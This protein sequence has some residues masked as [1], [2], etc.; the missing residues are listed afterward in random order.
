MPSPKPSLP[1]RA[2]LGRVKLTLPWHAQEL[3][4][5][6]ALKMEDT[7]DSDT[8]QAA[9]ALALT[10]PL[11]VPGRP[12]PSPIPTPHRARSPQP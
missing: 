12:S 10:L 3:E 2:A 8:V 5:N 1:A 11:T 7:V 4:T 9:P 6:V